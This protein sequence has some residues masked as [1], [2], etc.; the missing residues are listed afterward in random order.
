[1]EKIEKYIF[2][3]TTSYWIFLKEKQ[4]DKRFST[5]YYVELAHRMLTLLMQNNNLEC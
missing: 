2:P 5:N 4:N 3:R 1:M